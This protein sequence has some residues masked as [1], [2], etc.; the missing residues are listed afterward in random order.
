MPAGGAWDTTYY[1]NLPN[2][3]S[4]SANTVTSISIQMPQAN[5][6]NPAGMFER[7]GHIPDTRPEG[8]WEPD[9]MIWLKRRVREVCDLC[10]T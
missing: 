3:I 4:T 7:R 1:Y 8:S 10:P 6:Y 2:S 9:P 5:Y